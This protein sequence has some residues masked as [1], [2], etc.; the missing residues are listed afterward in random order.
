[1]IAAKLGAK[2]EVREERVVVVEWVEETREVW[3]REVVGRGRQ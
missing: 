2:E 3:V 1:M